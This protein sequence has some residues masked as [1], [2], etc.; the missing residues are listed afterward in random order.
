MFDWNEKFNTGI[1][2]VDEQHRELFRIAGRI[3]TLLHDQ[4]A[5]DKY[6][7]IVML[8]NELMDY[9]VYHFNT[10]EEYMQQIKYRKFFTHKVEHTDFIDKM[11]GIDVTKIDENQDEYIENILGLVAE[12]IVNHILEK[13]KAI[14]AE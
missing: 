12:W 14:S 11:K 5:F 7:T 10:E 1:P 6:D 2:V 4:Y 13:D 3:H 9:T 8:I